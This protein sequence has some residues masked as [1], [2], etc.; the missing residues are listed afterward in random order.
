MGCELKHANVGYVYIVLV[1]T[2]P[3]HHFRP[4]PLRLAN[5]FQRA[6]NNHAWCVFSL[7]SSTKTFNSLEERSWRP[8]SLKVLNM[9]LFCGLHLETFFSLKAMSVELHQFRSPVK[10][11]MLISSKRGMCDERWLM[12]SL[13]PH[14]FNT[15]LDQ[16][17][18]FDGHRSNSF[19]FYLEIRHRTPEFFI[20]SSN[21]G[22]RTL[23]TSDASPRLGFPLRISDGLHPWS[24]FVLLPVFVLHPSCAPWAD[25]NRLPTL[26]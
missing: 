7:V 26:L 15:F 5:F 11:G 24:S 19:F 18:F 6:V 1:P 2:L 13:L 8:Y 4:Q 14:R 17:F 23:H 3:Y 9:S 25:Y 22:V 10:K 20:V 16:H 21:Y 12:V